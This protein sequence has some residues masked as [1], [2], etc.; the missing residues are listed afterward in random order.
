MSVG[1]YYMGKGHVAV[2][3][4]R[5]PKTRPD[6]VVVKVAYAGV[7]GSDL[8]IYHGLMDYRLKPPRVFGHEGAGTIV[9]VGEEVESLSIGDRV[10]VCPIVPCGACPACEEGLPHLCHNFRLLGAD[11]PGC[12]QEYWTVPAY[13]AYR[14]SDGTRLDH[15]ALVEPVAVACHAVD[16]I[17]AVRENQ[18]AVVLGGGPIGVLVALVARL[19]GADVLLSEPDP[20][21]RRFSAELGI[22]VLDPTATDVVQEVDAW[23]GS[24]GADFVF[25]SS[26][27]QPAVS[28]MTKLPK[29]RGTIVVVSMFHYSPSI[30][31]L[32]CFTRETRMLVSRTYEPRDFQE[33]VRLCGPSGEL[34]LDDFVTEIREIREAPIVFRELDSSKNRLKVVLRVSQG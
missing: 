8:H 22:R 32:D 19:R 23:T 14:L 16:T 30:S 25:E 1:L 11:L 12:F 17:A 13:T 2:D 31:F 33:A 10:T 9:E 15:G 4:V 24:V 18:R 3:S 7:C 27:S 6:E 26:A 28:I 29:A 5:R 20:D 21:R 34:P